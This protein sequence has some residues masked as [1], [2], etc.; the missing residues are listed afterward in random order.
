MSTLPFLDLS[1]QIRSIRPEIDA[2]IADVI[3]SGEFMSGRLIHRV[4]QLDDRKRL[5]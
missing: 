5:R 1:H 3:D 2:A 4:Q